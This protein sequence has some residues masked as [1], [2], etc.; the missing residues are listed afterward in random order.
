[1]HRSLLAGVLVLSLAVSNNAEAQTNPGITVGLLSDG[2]LP[3]EACI[4]RDYSR[5]GSAML[6]GGL[7][8]GAPTPE[9]PTQR[10]PSIDIGSLF[11]PREVPSSAAG[12]LR[13]AL[14]QQSKV[15][16][17]PPEPTPTC[18]YPRPLSF[19]WDLITAGSKFKSP[20][21]IRAMSGPELD[22][23]AAGMIQ[24]KVAMIITLGTAATLAAHRATRTI[25]ILM[26]GV[27]DPVRLGLV[28]NLAQP[29]GNVTGI[30]FLA[31]ELVQKSIELLVQVSPKPSRIGVLWNPANPGAAMVLRAIE[32]GAA[33][34]GVALS[35]IEARSSADVPEALERA[36][37]M[38]ADGLVVLADRAFGNSRELLVEFAR[39]YRVPTAFQLRD[40][41]DAGGLL[42]YGPSEQDFNTLTTTYMMRILNG[43]SPADLPVEQP[44]RFDLV[45][46]LK[47]ANELGVTIPPSLLQRADQVIE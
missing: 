38:R 7:K 47:T 8:P 26:V 35:P 18:F 13:G 43:T 30:S 2:S 11:R 17:P 21:V 31:P 4:A 19:E 16:A 25:P 23:L 36:V 5:L 27:S 14:A 10:I 45:I 12:P 6:P 15:L 41:V 39:K 46:N 22:K 42:S 3:F 1:M 32:P 37:S 28:A 9:A 44:S 40:Y 24:H 33:S 34:L 29:G 20:F